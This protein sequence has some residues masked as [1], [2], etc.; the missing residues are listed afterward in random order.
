MHSKISAHIIGHLSADPR[1]F[2]LP[3]SGGAGCELRLTVARP[4]FD[5]N[6]GRITRNRYL[7]A[8]TYDTRLAAVLHRDYS[9]GDFVEILA[10][11]IRTEKPWYSQRQQTWLSGGVTV[12]LT[13]IRKVT[14][15]TPEDGETPAPEV[16]D[17]VNV[18]SRSEAAEPGTRVP[19]ELAARRRTSRG[20]DRREAVPHAADAASGSEAAEPVPAA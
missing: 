2:D 12:T 10:D 6:G 19:D 20:R 13:K 11:D 4:D 14:A 1:A 17:G 8:V 16:L 7:K 18:T 9:I 3:R 5:A 15:L